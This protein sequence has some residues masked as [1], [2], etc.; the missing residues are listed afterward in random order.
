MS[1][2]L[3]SNEKMIA[4]EW[5]KYAE[6]TVRPLPSTCSYYKN[7][8]QS[9]PNNESCLI[10]GGT[11]EIRSIFQEL[12]LK[13]T[14]TDQSELIVRAMGYLT[15]AAVPIAAN[16]ELVV[17]NWLNLEGV[18]NN[19]CDLLIGDDAINMVEWTQFELFLSNANRVL[20]SNGLFICHLL[21][22]PEECFITNK[23]GVVRGEYEDGMI[24]TKYDLASRLNFICYD[25][26]SYVMG[27][28]NTIEQLGINQLDQF[29]PSF[30]FVG[31]FG[32]CNSKFCCPPQDRFERLLDNY[33]HIEE[34][35]YPHE[36]EYCKFEP[37]YVLRKK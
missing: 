4:E 16:E 11:P 9:N 18:A 2:M 3:V 33:F 26:K 25:N 21:V 5:K 6:Y 28:Q 12:N 31:T 22:K 23:I 15:N 37:V 7:L 32:R 36:H 24:R 14:I 30:D 34:L 10:Y 1:Y 29:K 19:S 20:K 35:F 27:W 13:V 8:I 17:T